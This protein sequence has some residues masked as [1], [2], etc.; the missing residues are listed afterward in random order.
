MKRDGFLHMHSSRA[1][2]FFQP[3]YSRRYLCSLA[4]MS[5]L[6]AAC[7]SLE[8]PAPVKFPATP[9]P[10][11]TLKPIIASNAHSLAQIGVLENMQDHGRSFAV[12][13]TLHHDLPKVVAYI[14][15]YMF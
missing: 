14:H 11:S 4:T 9:T 8:S 3:V 1:K 10:R 5:I 6:V 13:D 12:D 15:G 2:P 7:Q